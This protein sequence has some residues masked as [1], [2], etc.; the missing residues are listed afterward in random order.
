MEAEDIKILF[1]SKK[2]AFVISSFKENIL[3]IE[4]IVKTNKYIHFIK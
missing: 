3:I 2:Q 1:L 4:F